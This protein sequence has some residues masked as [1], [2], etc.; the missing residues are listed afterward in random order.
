MM[1]AGFIRRA[2]IIKTIFDNR[3]IAIRWAAPGLLG[4]T[5]GIQNKE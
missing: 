1:A 3:K 2:A 5:K 4:I